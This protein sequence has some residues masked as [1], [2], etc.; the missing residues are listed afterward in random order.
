MA[1]QNIIMHKYT[2]LNDNFA[3][4]LKDENCK[5]DERNHRFWS[6]HHH[7]SQQRQKKIR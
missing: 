4:R 5:T 3:K 2:I 1:E 7:K 6:H